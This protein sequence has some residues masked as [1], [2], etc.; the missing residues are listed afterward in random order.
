[1]QFVLVSLYKASPLFVSKSVIN[2]MR[3][4]TVVHRL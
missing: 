1:M 2:M 3:T 4:M